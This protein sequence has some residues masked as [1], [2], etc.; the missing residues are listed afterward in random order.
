MWPFLLPGASDEWITV[1]TLFLTESIP[2]P[3]H[4]DRVA[5][6]LHIL[7]SGSRAV[8]RAGRGPCWPGAVGVAPKLPDEDSGSMSGVNQFLGPLQQLLC[9]DDTLP[10]PASPIHFL[11]S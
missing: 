6:R 1:E 3:G 8:K 11:P 9:A 5:P 10:F 2:S 4:R 7:G